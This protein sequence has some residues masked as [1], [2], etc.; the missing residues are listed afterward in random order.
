MFEVYTGNMVHKYIVY[1]FEVFILAFLIL[2][3]MMKFQ[4]SGVQSL[5]LRL[6]LIWLVKQTIQ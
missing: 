3:G 5:H 1:N 2:V 6:V 4:C